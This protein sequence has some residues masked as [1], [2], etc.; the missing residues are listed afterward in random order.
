MD[1]DK[2]VVYMSNIN[3]CSVPQTPKD[4]ESQPLFSN[5]E[6]VKRVFDYRPE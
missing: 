6:V 3:S 1:N 5:K 2:K 4:Y